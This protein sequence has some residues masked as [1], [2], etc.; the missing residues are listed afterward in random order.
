MFITYSWRITVGKTFKDRDKWEQKQRTPEGE[1]RRTKFDRRRLIQQLDE[2]A[3]L[4]GDEAVVWGYDE[5]E[6]RP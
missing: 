5:D 3:E 6:D 2:E 4:Y 1:V